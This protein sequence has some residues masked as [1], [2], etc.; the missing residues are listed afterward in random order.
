[1][2]SARMILVMDDDAREWMT[3]D[4]LMAQLGWE[5]QW[6]PSVNAAMRCLE[7][8]RFTGVLVNHFAEEASSERLLNWLRERGREEA[9]I[10]MSHQAD[11]DLMIN[12]VNQGA[13]DL[14]QAPVQLADL[15]RALDL[16][17][18]AK[19]VSSGS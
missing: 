6:A 19:A 3:V 8:Q 11:Y 15:R 14:I 5:T 12:L 10:I 13:V 18:E 7:Q 16:A 2:N 9:V 4:R 1:M 17:L